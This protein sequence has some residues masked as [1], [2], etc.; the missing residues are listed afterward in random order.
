MQHEL[1]ALAELQVRRKFFTKATNRQTNAAG[2]LVR[3]ALGWQADEEEAVRDKIKVKAAKIVA[4][5]LSGKGCDLPSVASDMEVIAQSIEPLTTVRH[6]CELTMRR[7]VRKL[8]IW[9]SWGKGVR[10]LGDL[11]MAVILAECGDLNKYANPAKVWKRLG[12]APFEKDGQTK[13]LSTWRKSGGLTAE[14]WADGKKTGYSPSRR[15]EI[16]SCVGDPLFRQQTMIT[17]PYRKIYDDRRARTAETHP[18]WTKLHS[19]NDGLRIMTKR[20]ISD[21]W[22]EWRRATTPMNSRDIVP[23]AEEYAQAGRLAN[24]GVKSTIPLPSAN[25]SASAGNGASIVVLTKHELPH[26]KDAAQAAEH[27]ANGRVKS[28][29]ML[30]DAH[31]H[32]SQEASGAIMLLK[33]REV[34]PRS[35]HSAE[36]AGNGGQLARDTQSP[37]ASV[38]SHAADKAARPAIP[39]VKSISAVPDASHPNAGKPAKR[40]ATE[41]TKPTA[42]LPGASLPPGE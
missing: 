1:D 4:K 13:A 18:D 2:A 41:L 26:S 6:E 35:S 7:I 14:E 40:R 37:S 9:E 17:G 8:P 15:A 22:S 12:L 20:L 19:H 27:Q 36:G 39:A 3:R 16:F 28:I 5:A 29:D 21:L 25:P 24:T 10:G 30:P 32:A 31:S 42:E 23:A 11:G 34:L 38:P 33:P